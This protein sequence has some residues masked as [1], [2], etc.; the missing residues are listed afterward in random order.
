MS[1]FLEKVSA[2]FSLLAITP[3]VSAADL[4]S[5]ESKRVLFCAHTQDELYCDERSAN[6]FLIQ[7]DS[8]SACGGMRRRRRGELIS[9]RGSGGGAFLS[10]RR[11][12]FD[13]R[14]RAARLRSLFP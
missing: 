6:I 10:E 5:S 11:F 13:I 8:E 14:E 4:L 7:A 3:G 9:T 2:R 12:G 1:L